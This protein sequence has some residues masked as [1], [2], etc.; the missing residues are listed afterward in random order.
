MILHVVCRLLER[1]L[2][3]RRE[4][5][6]Q[7][8]CGALR[9]RKNCRRRGVSRR[10]AD[11]ARAL[12][13]FAPDRDRFGPGARLRFELREA[14]QPA[15]SLR[16]I[17]LIQPLVLERQAIL[18][19]PVLAPELAQP[20][21]EAIRDVV[22]VEDIVGGVGQLLMR[23]RPFRPVGASLAFGHRD[24]Q[25]RLD[26]FRVAH[27]RFEADA[28]GGDLRV[29]YRGDDA[30]GAEINGFQVL[31][32][33]VDDLARGRRGQRGQQRLET[34]DAQRVDAPDLVPRGQLQQ[35][36]LGE[37]RA[38]A[39]ELRVDADRGLLLERLRQRGQ[40]VVSIDPNRVRH[41]IDP[42][43]QFGIDYD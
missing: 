38:F 22:E 12:E 30:L 33:S 21:R 13:L 27:L 42:R 16:G 37:K 36:E 14:A 28:P 29:E 43:V 31:T 9:N 4:A 8:R 20:Q 6:V 40:L 23:E 15:P 35:A 3:I 2:Q 18:Q 7:G 25:Q 10:A 17:G 41:T 11:R 24:I 26:Q 19:H 32:R 34:A 5:V 1:A 39:Q